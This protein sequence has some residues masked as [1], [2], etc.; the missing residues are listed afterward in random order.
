MFRRSSIR[1][2]QSPEPVT[3][4]Q[5][6]AQVWDERIGSA[7]VQARSWRLA[8]FGCLALS[9]GLSAGLVWQSARGT[10]VPW[11]VEIDKLGQAQAVAPANANYRPSDPQIA[12]HLARFIEEVRAIPA[13]PI[14]LRQ[15]WL[16]AYDFATSK[17][18]LALNDHAR[19]NDPFAQVG[20]IQ[21]AV[22]VSSVIR[23]SPDSFR[24]A[25]T[26]RRYQ[27]GA[28]AETSRW[29]AILTIAVQTP[30]TPDALRRNPLGLF[31]D[32]LNWSKELSQ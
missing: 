32:A 1:Y 11:V 31:V 14:V 24:V 26:E 2:G 5:R 25:W 6:A 22:D 23:A 20:K 21:V 12:F 28:L 19:A 8:F 27:D 17:G 30:R 18:T 13:D 7:R 29:S 16:R 9:G 3:P 4:Y 10:I 15:N